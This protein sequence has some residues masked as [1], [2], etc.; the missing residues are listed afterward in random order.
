MGQRAIPHR[1]VRVLPADFS[2]EERF[3]YR[4]SGDART[5]LDKPVI[6]KRKGLSIVT[7]PTW[8]SSTDHY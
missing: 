7:T 3:C 5:S 6:L 1:R 4:P 2:V 8:L